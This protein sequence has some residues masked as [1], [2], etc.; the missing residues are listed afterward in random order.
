[1]ANQQKRI[2]GWQFWVDFEGDNV[3]KT[4]KT[5]KEI[6]ENIGK[7]L[8]P[9]GRGEEVP[10]LVES[11]IRDIK[12]SK[13]IIQKLKIPR[14]LLADLEFKGNRVKQKKA[15]VL[16][17]ALNDKRYSRRGL[18]NRSVEFYGNLWGY[19]IHEKTFKFHSNLG[20]LN[21]KIVLIDSFELTD[22]FDQV[23][24]QIIGKKWEQKDKYKNRLSPSLLRYFINQANRYWTVE[25]LSE[26]WGRKN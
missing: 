13:R 18:I 17:D 11:I 20:V 8:A 21:G 4:P 19:G 12:G 9:K 24:K 14:L 23:K 1:M 10:K 3:I 15:V 22:N 25:N 6:S 5:K 16:E 26:L 7:Y 2:G